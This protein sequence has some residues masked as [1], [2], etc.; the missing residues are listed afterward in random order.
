MRNAFRLLESLA[1]SPDGMR[2]TR[3][4]DATG[5]PKSSV[6]RILGTL[7]DLEIVCREEGSGIYHL[8]ASWRRVVSPPRL[9]EF[10]APVVGQDGKAVAGLTLRL[11]GQV[12]PGAPSE[13]LTRLVSDLAHAVSRRIRS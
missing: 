11:R 10:S 8:T 9:T 4:A 3:L 12:S 13:R 5:L 6:H 7:A 2:L 1:G